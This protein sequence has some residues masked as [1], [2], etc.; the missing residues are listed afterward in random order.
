MGFGSRQNRPYDMN[1]ELID[2][3][4]QK[5]LPAEFREEI[6]EMYQSTQLTGLQQAEDI[7][8]A[9]RYAE[10][11]R[12][13]FGRHNLT[14]DEE[15]PEMLC[16]ERVGII[17]RY[18]AILAQQDPKNFGYSAYNQG[19]KE[20]LE[21][22]FGSKCLPDENSSNVDE[23]G[24]DCKDEPKLKTGDKVRVIKTF[25]DGSGYEYLGMTGE[26]I[27]VGRLRCRIF[28]GLKEVSL[29][30]YMFEVI[31]PCTEPTEED[32]KNKDNL[33]DKLHD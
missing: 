25:S 21:S 27:R 6:K 28:N 8:R 16:V 20:L 10:A 12:A 23:I 13:I 26:V 3:V 17:D 15:Y 32:M 11:M 29:P 33:K 5:C 18:T 19:K 22:L 1:K 4:W 2:Y 7:E 9:D 14:S 30:Q 24:K 31:E